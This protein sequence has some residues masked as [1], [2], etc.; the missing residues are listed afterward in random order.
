M[1]RR[2]GESKMTEAARVLGRQE[3]SDLTGSHIAAFLDGG[4]DREAEDVELI[5]NAG[6]KVEGVMARW[7][8]AKRQVNLPPI[9]VVVLPMQKAEGKAEPLTALPAQ[10]EEVSWKRRNWGGEGAA[11]NETE[12]SLFL[13]PT[14]PEVEKVEATPEPEAAKPEADAKP[15]RGAEEGSTEEAYTEDDVNPAND[16]RRRIWR[17]KD[18]LNWIA[19]DDEMLSKVGA[20]LWR[21]SE[22]NREAGRTVW[23]DWLEAH[24]VDDA[25]ARA[26]WAKG[27]EGWCKA[28]DLYLV[29]QRNGWRYPVAQNLNRL[30]E[31]VERVEGALVRVGVDLYQSGGKLV[32][33]VSVMVD[34]TKG[35]KTRIARLVDVEGSFLKAELTRHVDFFDWKKDA[36]SPKAPSPDV[37]SALLSRYGK[38]SFPTITGI[39]CAPTLRRDGTVLAK[40]GFD[41]ATGLL[42]RGPLPEMP[43]V[44][45]KPTEQDALNAV[46]VLDKL[47]DEFP[48]V[49]PASRS[50]ALSGLLT[51]VCRAALSCVPMHA[52]TAPQAGT[53]KSYLWDIIAAIAIGDAMPV[54]AAGAKLEET[55]K[56]IDAQV[57]KGFTML[58]ID[59]ASIHLGG[60]ELC[61]VVERPAYAP[62]ILGKSLMKERRNI[63]TIFATGNNLRLRDDVTR[64]SLLVRLDAE[65]ERPEM[66]TFKA[67][68]FDTVL[69]SRGLYLWAALT[70][71][72]AYQAA[73][74]PDRLPGIGDPFAEWSDQIRSALV[75]LGYDD[76][77]L[78]MEAVRDNDPSRQARVAM[79]QA[80]SNA[81]GV[82]VVRTA[83][84]MIADAKTGTTNEP[85]K[86][87]LD[88]RT[89]PEA[90]NLRAAII[91][92]TDNKMDA[93]YLGNKLNTDKGKIAGGLRLCTKYDS[94]TKVNH[95]YVE[96]LIK[97]EEE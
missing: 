83:S 19:P 69:A 92:Y 72:L 34:A 57:I 65:M 94:H 87:L 5:R 97:G 41:A 9:E 3:V 55:A 84:L 53:G 67:N 63:W 12:V 88:H 61:Q 95:W 18:A 77:V 47:F 86:H 79:F 85:G 76:P 27:F 78:T 91:Q 16:I 43:T 29:A 54:I 11:P 1:E 93:R 75:W 64:R 71:V 31:I 17:I 70:I 38:W 4:P 60:D 52:S 50:V 10:K 74:M 20:V 40:E 26:Q 58:S 36:R 15:E 22:G 33:P 80:I 7:A 48:F 51:T 59:N 2:V 28:E 21:V 44:A 8:E 42:V 96:T 39:I 73:G 46:R 68:P 13:K 37:V 24:G 23:V 25:T 81:Y 62:R 89:N 14:Q 6:L 30:E 32:R 90:A 82:G 49:D 35:R 45:P 66:R 56:R